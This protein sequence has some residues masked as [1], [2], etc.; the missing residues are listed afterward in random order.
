MF[1]QTLIFF[2][3]FE[4]DCELISNNMSISASHKVEIFLWIFKI[5]NHCQV[6]SCLVTKIKNGNSILFMVFSRPFIIYII[7]LTTITNVE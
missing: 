7:E 5:L 1:V 6:K 4:L 3:K 2:I